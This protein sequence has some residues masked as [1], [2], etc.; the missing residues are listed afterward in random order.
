MNTEMGSSHPNLIVPSRKTFDPIYALL[1]STSQSRNPVL[2]ALKP[3]VNYR[4]RNMNIS[5]NTQCT[6]K[7]Q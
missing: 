7:W 3:M 6:E 4:R 1:H 5:K 2:L